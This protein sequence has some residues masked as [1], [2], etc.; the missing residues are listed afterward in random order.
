MGTW[1]RH[2]LG[3]RPVWMNLLMLFCAWMALVY[4]P[5]DLLVKPVVA[6]EE[7]WFGV[8]FHGAWAKL[9]ALPH[10]LVYAAGMVGFW[11]MRSW[12][13]P[14]AAVYAGQVS[15]AMLVWPLL[16]VG[17]FRG[18]LTG[19][20]SGGLFAIPTVALWRA[21]ER[22]REGRPPLAERYGRWA[23]V[24]GASAGIGREF[25]R[26]L[27]REGVS[28][29]L[30]ARREDALKALSEE[31]QQRHDVETRV[32]AADLATAAGVELLLAEIS[33]LEVSILVNNAGFGYSGRFDL[34]D[35]DRLVEMVQLNCAAP[36]ALTS[37]RSCGP[38]RSW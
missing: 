1:I 17:G 35:R 21:R 18:L 5:W 29:V 37:G 33:D 15:I 9:L 19:L 30:N 38:A 20:V 22:F 26:A 4:V 36:V 10:E 12:M 27:A 16:Y 2:Q 6:D 23:L 25:A 28:C 34:Q 11:Q 7:V 32:V 31:L 24:T 14:W 8:R 3:R 13:W